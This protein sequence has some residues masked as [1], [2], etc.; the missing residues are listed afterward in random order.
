MGSSCAWCVLFIVLLNSSLFKFFFLYNPVFLLIFSV[1]DRPKLESRYCERVH[2]ALA[3]AKEIEDFDDLVDPRHL[4][5][6]CLGPEPSKYVLEKIRRKEKSKFVFAILK[7]NLSSLASSLLCLIANL[8]FWLI[9]MAIRYSKEKYVRIRGIK[10]EYL[11]S[12]AA[13]SKKRKLGSEKGDIVVLPSV[14]I[15]PSSPTQSLEV[16]AFTPFTTRSKGKGK[17]GKSVW[18]DLATTLGRA[19]NV[20]IDKELKSLI[21]IPS[22]ELVSCHIHKLV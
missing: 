16:A 14:Q 3:F 11:S 20:V 21:S 8:T 15:A 17:V 6:C 4:F 19:H 7:I 10:N 5:N 22:H 1:S 2:S 9:E 12:L 18:D 13:E